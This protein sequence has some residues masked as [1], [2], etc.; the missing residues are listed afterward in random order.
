M[1]IYCIVDTKILHE[2]EIFYHT[3]STYV[4][5]YFNEPD[6]DDLQTNIGLLWY[7]YG[8]NEIVNDLK[9]ADLVAFNIGELYR[10]DKSVWTR[11]PI[12]IV[13]AIESKNIKHIMLVNPEHTYYNKSDNE[14]LELMDSL[15]FEQ[16][17]EDSRIKFLINT[18]VD[19]NLN[20]ETKR[21]SPY[22]FNWNVRERFIPNNLVGC[23]DEHINT[24]K[25][26]IFL[27]YCH[28]SSDY[29]EKLQRFIE[30]HGLENKVYF[31]NIG[32]GIYLDYDEK[33]F[34][35]ITPWQFNYQSK[36]HY[37]NSY[38]SV[39]RE[40]VNLAITEKTWKAMIN[41]HPFIYNTSIENNEKYIR[42]LKEMGF[43]TFDKYFNGTGILQKIENWQS[44]D[45][46]EWFLSVK[47]D[48]IYNRN[49]LFNF[50]MKDIL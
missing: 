37:T 25:E 41:F 32:S 13:R 24:I 46:V 28:Q 21:F 1:K 9:E 39:I 34:E 11:I 49:R 15:I 2:R 14:I 45:S 18:I 23:F 6:I 4:F 10:A 50:D 29:Q 5:N 22:M 35:H 36:E 40:T 19:L 17:G 47:E 3:A 43:R 42:T 44:V 16:F 12:Q 33:E 38:F 48:V 8:D 31:S 30:K 20:Y 27:S 26:K 7:N